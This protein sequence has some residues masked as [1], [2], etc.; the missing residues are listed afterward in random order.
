MPRANAKSQERYLAFLKERLRAPMKI[1]AMAKK[2]FLRF[3][4]SAI[5]KFEHREVCVRE[6]T[7]RKKTGASI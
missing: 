4:E 2:D 1:G 3:A 7:E 5:K 6:A